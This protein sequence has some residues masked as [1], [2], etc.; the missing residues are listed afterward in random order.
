VCTVTAILQEEKAQG[1]SV[2]RASE[3]KPAHRTADGSEAQKP[4]IHTFP[5][6]AAR[7]LALIFSMMSGEIS[8]TKI[9]RADAE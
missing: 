4:H 2:A 7:L 6:F 1:R 8:P 9:N 3:K 5:R